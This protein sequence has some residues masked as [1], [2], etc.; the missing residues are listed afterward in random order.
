MTDGILLQ[1]LESDPQ[2]R[3]YDTLIID[4]AHERS[5]NIDLLLGVLQRL[6]PRRPDLRL[7]VTSATIDPGRLSAFFGGAPVIEVS[8]RSYPGGGPLS[9]ARRRRRG[10]RGAVAA[11]RAS[12][13]PCASS[14]RPP[15]ARSA[16]TLVF[17][18]GEK[19]IRE[20]AEA[21][22][23]ARLPGPR[24][25]RSTRGSRPPTRRASSR[26]TRQ[27]RV[28]LATN[29][30][31]TSLTVPGIRYVIDSGLARIS[32]YS[33][34]GKVQR[35]HVERIS[36][37]SAEQRQ[38]PLRPRGRGHLHPPLFGGG[39]RRARGVHAPRDPAHQP[40]ERDPAH[41]GARPRRS[42]ELSR[43]SILPIRG[44]STTACG[45]S[46]SCRR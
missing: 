33:P 40:G 23:K 20:A 28:I 18:P 6:L 43:S 25:C 27:R 9:P 32:R 36:Q 10:R 45:F 1:E 21:L 37:A 38:G 14:T 13:R 41:G 26:S 46:R 35:L 8:G 16:D 30:A 44:S 19:H 11:R 24:C 17:L 4:E 42:G 3:R 7:I 15:A 2:L 31:E 29:V 12:S 34:R 5:L 22:A 39:F